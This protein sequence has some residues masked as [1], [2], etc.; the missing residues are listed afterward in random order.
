MTFADLLTYLIPFSVFNFFLLTFVFRR[1]TPWWPRLRWPRSKGGR[2]R[3][4]R[5]RCRYWWVPFHDYYF[6]GFPPAVIRSTVVVARCTNCAGIYVWQHVGR[7]FHE[8]VFF[9][10]S[11]PLYTLVVYQ[12]PDIVEK[13]S[14]PFLLFGARDH[15]RRSIA[16]GKLLIDNT[17]TIVRCP[18]CDLVL[19]RWSRFQTGHNSMHGC[20][21]GGEQAALQITGEFHE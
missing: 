6:D 8:I 19:K 2:Q 5:R 17:G 7:Q 15:S 14:C 13:R 21:L 10:P 11:P 20:M 1:L 16:I 4:A 9:N 3:G 12:V 18:G